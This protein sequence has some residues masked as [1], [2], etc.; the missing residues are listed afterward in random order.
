VSLERGYGAGRGPSW[1]YLSG[2]VPSRLPIWADGKSALQTGQRLWPVGISGSSGVTGRSDRGI[3]Y[4]AASTTSW[5]SFLDASSLL[6]SMS[7]SV[8]ALLDLS[9]TFLRPKSPTIWECQR[10][11]K[12]GEEFAGSAA[13]GGSLVCL[14]SARLL[15]SW[16]HVIG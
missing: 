13:K 16:G 5:P 2:T 6:L 1:L 15:I 11:R 14:R 10:S 3:F 4:V 12:T 8:L 9:Q 7:T